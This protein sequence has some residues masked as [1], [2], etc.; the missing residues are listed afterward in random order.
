MYGSAD[1]DPY[2]N[3]IGC[4][5]QIR[6]LIFY[7]S[8]IPDRGVKKAPDPGSAI[9]VKIIF[10]CRCTQSLN[11]G[12]ESAHHE[13]LMTKVRQLFL[14]I[15]TLFLLK[16]RMS[17]ARSIA[18]FAVAVDIFVYI[19]LLILR[20]I[21]SLNIENCDRCFCPL[22]LLSVHCVQFLRWSAVVFLFI[23]NLMKNF[24]C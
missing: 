14:L 3:F 17:R 11:Q 7:P 22:K 18:I 20:Q 8:L 2:K 6:I 9:L 19:L 1:S 24:C 23:Q 12:L 16:E 10:F 5:F 13:E 15:I 21:L 4:S